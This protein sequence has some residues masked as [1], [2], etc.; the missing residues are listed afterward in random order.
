MLTKLYDVYETAGE[1]EP[2]AVT[3]VIP[4]DM[5]RDEVV[6]NILKTVEQYN[7]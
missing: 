5:T 6:E 3:V 2:N 1:D 7:H 4:K